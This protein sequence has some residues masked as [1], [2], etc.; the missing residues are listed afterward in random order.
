MTN[1][2]PKSEPGAE[3]T[4]EQQ[5]AGG[6][7]GLVREYAAFLRSNKKWYLLPILLALTILGALVFIAGSSAA[8]FIYALF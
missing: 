7:R 8:P 4:L 6:R 3:N 5:V 2:S 1:I